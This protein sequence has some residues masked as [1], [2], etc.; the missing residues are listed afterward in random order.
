MAN[1][2]TA[3]TSTGTGTAARA[4]DPLRGCPAAGR[5]AR[6]GRAPAAPA[7]LR[8]HTGS[9]PADWTVQ[10]RLRADCNGDRLTDTVGVAQNTD[11]RQIHPTRHNQEAWNNNPRSWW[12]RSPAGTGVSNWRSGVP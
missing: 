1:P 2:G 9:T 11:P 7:D 12:T 5:C 4:S 3:R 6:T 8:R 10:Q